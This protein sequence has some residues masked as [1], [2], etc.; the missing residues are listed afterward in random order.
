MYGTNTNTSTFTV[1]DV[2]KTFESCEADI[3]TIARR[4]GKWSMVYV[5]EIFHDIILLAENDYL[6][7]VDIALV[8][9]GSDTVVKASKFIVN[10]G[11]SATESER[12]GKNNDWTDLPNTHLSIILE[13]TSE[14]KNLSTENKNTFR[15]K[16]KKNW[17]N[18]SIDNSFPHLN[19]NNAQL[20]AS[21]GYELQKTNYK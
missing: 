9:D 12:A 5:D 20:Y 10:N 21:K 2:R 3:R 15:K 19:K 17:V 7:S 16:F 14:W 1:L 13:Y 4:T 6:H 18:S 11:G 8:K